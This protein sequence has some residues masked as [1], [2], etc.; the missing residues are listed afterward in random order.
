M[1]VTA[2]MM[3]GQQN[4]AKCERDGEQ[5]TKRRHEE[6]KNKAP[7]PVGSTCD[8]DVDADVYP[9]RVQAAPAA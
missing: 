8:A 3:T 7:H 1:T 2:V 5:E 6:K 9:T 4:G